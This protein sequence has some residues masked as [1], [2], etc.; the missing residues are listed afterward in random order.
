MN[1]PGR[2]IGAKV[3]LFATRPDKTNDSGFADVDWFRITP[4][5]TKIS[6]TE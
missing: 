2:W 6:L 1:L 4:N 3:G 5:T